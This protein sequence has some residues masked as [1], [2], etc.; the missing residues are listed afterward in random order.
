MLCFDFLILLA[1]AAFQLSANAALVLPKSEKSAVLC[2][3]LKNIMDENSFYHIV[4]AETTRSPFWLC[5]YNVSHILSNFEVDHQ[6]GATTSFSYVI[7][8][9]R[10]T[11]LGSVLT[12]LQFKIN[13]N[14]RPK[15]V[16]VY[17][18]ELHSQLYQY[19]E[20]NFV[21][22]L[23]LEVTAT[24][25]K[26]VIRL[27]HR[28]LYRSSTRCDKQEI[29]LLFQT[30]KEE[31]MPT[32]VDLFY[33]EKLRNLNGCPVR[34]ITEEE[35][36][37]VL[38]AERDTGIDYYGGIDVM[39]IR[40]IL[41]SLNGSVNFTEANF[42]GRNNLLA[43]EIWTGI[44]E[45]VLVKSADVVISSMLLT[46]E[47]IRVSDFVYPHV[48]DRVVWVVKHG[49][50]RPVWNAPF[51][52]FPSVMW[53]MILIC[54]VLL[55]IFTY[56]R[57]GF[58]YSLTAFCSPTLPAN[59]PRILILIVVGAFVLASAYKSF[60]VG[61]LINPGY[62]KQVKSVSEMIQLD[63]KYGLQIVMTLFL[64]SEE[65]PQMV[66]IVKTS[67]VAVTSTELLQWVVNENYA[68][69]LL[70]LAAD[71]YRHSHFVDNDGN[72]LVYKFRDHYINFYSCMYMWRGH[73]L[74]AAFNDAVFH[75]MDAGL[76]KKWNED[77]K[78]TA[79]LKF[80]YNTTRNEEMAFFL[81]LQQLQG[82][83]GAYIVGHVMSILVFIAEI[84][85]KN[86]K[87]KS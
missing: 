32:N 85:V 18:G 47:R 6:M 12:F 61:I 46:N 44:F 20:T 11:N 75:I 45:Y 22:H 72:P 10:T 33:N 25:N 43:N 71:Y 67:R 41:E 52:V 74:L 63:F 56:P 15:L 66:N 81:R 14:T 1:G 34:I 13:W 26:S 27:Y 24:T 83:L 29:E 80:I 51:Y 8:V 30:E 54:Y 73:P 49:R 19:L 42:T 58:N 59:T 68:V 55:M 78:C 69:L 16:V 35:P 53:L 28:P 64:N 21:N 65:D 57:R 5:E 84:L 70:E 38:A 62:E 76:I 7:F 48:Q 40:T 36:P 4:A 23:L 60:L 77:L 3:I 79:F 2:G 9:D 86:I 31:L 37:Y 50:K 87:V 82:I 17:E 39:T